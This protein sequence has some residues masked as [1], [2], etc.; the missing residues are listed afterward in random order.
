LSLFSVGK[1]TVLTLWSL[2]APPLSLFSMCVFRLHDCYFQLPPL[3]KLRGYHPTLWFFAFPPQAS[4]LCP[5][6]SSNAHV[7]PGPQPIPSSRPPP[8][9]LYRWQPTPHPP[10]L[11]FVRIV[12]S[13]ISPPCLLGLFLTPPHRTSSLPPIPRTPTAVVS[14]SAPPA[15]ETPARLVFHSSL[16]A[17][18]QFCCLPPHPVFPPF[19]LG[20]CFLSMHPTISSL[21]CPRV[22]IEFILLSQII[23]CKFVLFAL[24]R[25]SICFSPRFPLPFA[26]PTMQCALWFLPAAMRRDAVLFSTLTLP[27]LF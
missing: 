23:L 27:V 17:Y 1:G 2:Y 14:L 16:S 26:S 22:F 13:P 19:V 11:H 15:D 24:S 6:F 21:S 5:F 3:L 12:P 7:R 20:V 4:C 9:T 25:A 10:L 18:S 8:C